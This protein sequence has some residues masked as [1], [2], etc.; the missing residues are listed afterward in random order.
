MAARLTPAFVAAP[1]SGGC[2]PNSSSDSEPPCKR[3]RTGGLE[4]YPAGHKP[5]HGAVYSAMN[6]QDAMNEPVVVLERDQLYYTEGADCVIRVESTLFRVRLRPPTNS[7]WILTLDLTLLALCRYTDSCW[8][9][10]HRRSRICSA[11]R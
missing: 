4:P 5:C 3:L 6:P 8:R 1:M 2:R 10:I 7:T 11:F 9:A